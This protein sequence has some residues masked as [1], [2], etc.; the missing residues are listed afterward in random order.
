MPR[1]G[2][3]ATPDTGGR[4]VAGEE[5]AR[6]PGGSRGAVEGIDLAAEERA[7]RRDSILAIALT[8]VGFAAAFRIGPTI[9]DPPVEPGAR[10]AFAA[11]VCRCLPSWLWW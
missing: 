11:A 1:R 3:A 9:T 5:T 6:P 8:L 10:H 7:I 2:P 4:P